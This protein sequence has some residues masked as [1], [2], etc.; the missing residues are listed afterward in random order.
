MFNSPY[1]FLFRSGKVDF[2]FGITVFILTGKEST[3]HECARTAGTV[4]TKITGCYMASI[5]WITSGWATG[6]EVCYNV[7]L[8]EYCNLATLLNFILKLVKVS[9]G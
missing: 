9:A 6:E 4:V 8:A 7:T 5:G 1:V 2:D 3:N